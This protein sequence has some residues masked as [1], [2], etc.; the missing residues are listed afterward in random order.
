M[1]ADSTVSTGG[2]LDMEHESTG[3]I[4]ALV[5]RA[6]GGDRSAFDELIGQVRPKLIRWILSRMS[7][8]LRG[9]VEPEDVLQETCLWAFRS[10][11]K[12]EWRGGEAFEHWLF[13]IA[14]HVVLKEVSRLGRMDEQVLECEPPLDDPSPSRAMRRE[15]RLDR[16]EA[17][18]LSLS[19]D[20]R[21]VLDLARLRGMPIREIAGRMKRSPDAVSHLLSRALKSLRDKFGDT[22][23]L[24]LPERALEVRGGDD[25]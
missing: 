24:G 11:G 23:S 2:M 22:E 12:I 18:L 3:R 10:I 19:P 6:Q 4:E 25:D 17:A 1:D 16:L 15:E 14:K 7:P 8:N 21:R 13:S 5:K 20:H 9:K